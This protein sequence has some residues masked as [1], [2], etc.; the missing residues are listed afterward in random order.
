MERASLENFTQK[1]DPNSRYSVRE[2]L[3]E[4]SYGVVYRGKSIT[5]N[6][7]YAIKILRC[8]FDD[9]NLE[10]VAEEISI[11]KNLKSPYI[12]SFHE[13]FIFNDEMWIIME[14]CGG[15]SLTDLMEVMKFQV[16]IISIFY[17]WPGAQII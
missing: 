14:C 12:V 16:G 4:G 11:L 10:S 15:G 3:G 9:Q 6:S 1:I 13:S 17:S 5:S 2:L 8:E 7:E